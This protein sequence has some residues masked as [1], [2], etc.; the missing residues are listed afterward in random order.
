[1]STK[2]YINW[3]KIA[4]AAMYASVGGAAMY[5]FAATPSPAPVPVINIPACPACPACPRTSFVLDGVQIKPQG[6]K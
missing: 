3:S 2:N 4:T 5:L 6:G 1:M